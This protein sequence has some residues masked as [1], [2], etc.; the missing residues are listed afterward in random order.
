MQ[1]ETFLQV[2]T[3]PWF[4]EGLQYLQ[5]VSNGDTA[6]LH[7][8]ITIYS[9][10]YCGHIFYDDFYIFFIYSFFLF[11]MALKMIDGD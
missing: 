1:V 4:S 8:A 9:H 2:E 3:N 5:G 6:V 10:W 11:E 7:W